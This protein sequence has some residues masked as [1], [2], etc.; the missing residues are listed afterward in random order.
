MGEEQLAAP[1]S[2]MMV[3]ALIFYVG[4][5][6][7]RVEYIVAWCACK[8]EE[9]VGEERETE[10]EREIIHGNTLLSSGS[11]SSEL[12]SFLFI[13]SSRILLLPIFKIDHRFR[14]LATTLSFL[15]HSFFFFSSESFVLRPPK[16]QI[17]RC[18]FRLRHASADS[19]SQNRILVFCGALEL[20]Q[21]FP[22][23]RLR[24]LRGSS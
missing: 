11:P 17:L 14:V 1:E 20:L 16:T 15:I 7:K 22:R 10:R 6:L 21:L 24:S 8:E 13:S 23:L 9:E 3:H 5:K 18:P 2:T 4:P 19:R 12:V